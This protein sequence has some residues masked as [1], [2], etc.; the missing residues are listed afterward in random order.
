MNA[1]TPNSIRS[2]LQ[3][4]RLHLVDADPAVVQDALYDAEEYLRGELAENPQLS[5]ADVVSKVA[6]SYGAPEEVAQIYLEGEIKIERALRPPPAPRRN[7]LLGR[8]FAVGADPRAY[9]GLFY[10]LLALATGIV[11]FTIAVAGVSLS[12][13]LSI[14]IIGLPFVILFLSVVRVLS[15]VEGRIVE[16]ML[17]VRMPRRPLYNSGR[18]QPLLTRIGALFTDARTWTT[19]LY[20][21]LMLPLGVIYFTVAVSMTAI[22][23]GMTLAPVFYSLWLLGVVSVEHDVTIASGV[24]P[25]WLG[26]PLSFVIGVFLLFAVLH[27]AKGVAKVHGGLAKHLLVA[28]NSQERDRD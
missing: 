27:L 9:A 12:M 11:Y 8:Y 28:V 4:L 10:M 1:P 26:A 15:L 20:L 7:S 22:G 3:A 25:P 13:G 2:Y 6:R 23:A 5:E 19:L 14:L 21:V 24:L 16:V 18:G 17:G